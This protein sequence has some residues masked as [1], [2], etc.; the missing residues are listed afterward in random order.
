MR[1]PNSSS[2]PITTS[3]GSELPIIA[4]SPGATPNS[5]STRV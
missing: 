5:A 3:E 1:S 4:N 2:E